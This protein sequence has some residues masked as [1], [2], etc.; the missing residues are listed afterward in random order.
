MTKCKT[1]LGLAL[2]LYGKHI[3]SSWKQ[4]TFHFEK[5]NI[6]LF[7]SATAPG[8]QLQAQFCENISNKLIGMNELSSI[9]RINNSPTT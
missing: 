4:L 8:K 6:D 7:K 1:E 2:F 3:A 9:Y 5:F